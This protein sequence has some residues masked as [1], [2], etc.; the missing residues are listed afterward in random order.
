VVES[1]GGA[2]AESA[3][4]IQY[5]KGWERALEALRICWNTQRDRLADTHPGANPSVTW[6]DWRLAMVD[7]EI[8]NPRRARDDLKGKGLIECLSGNEYR[9]KT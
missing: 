7:L 8:S 3:E 9:P 5:G 1:D 4:L 2:A 6:E